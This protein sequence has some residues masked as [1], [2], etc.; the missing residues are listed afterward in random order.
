[1]KEITFSTKKDL[2]LIDITDKVNEIVEESEVKQGVVLIYPLHATAAITICESYDPNMLKDLEDKIK[3]LFPKG[4][5]YRHDKI[6]NNAH[7]HLISSFFNPAQTVPVK[8]GK[9][10]M[11]TW[12][13][14][15]FIEADGP[16]QRRIVVEVMKS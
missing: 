14:I 16:K 5:G 7:S 4:A 1:M 10:Y 15:I 12:Q 2:E 11:G 6:D 9:L 3:E 8:D 13:A